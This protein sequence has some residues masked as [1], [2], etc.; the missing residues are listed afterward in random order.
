MYNQLESI[1]IQQ[2]DVPKTAVHQMAVT[3]LVITNNSY[4]SLVL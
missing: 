2:G 4:N 3:L 1:Y